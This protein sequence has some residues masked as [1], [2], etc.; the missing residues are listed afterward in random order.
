MSGKT[1]RAQDYANAVSTGGAMITTIAVPPTLAA[2]EF[3]RDY[4]LGHCEGF[5]V[6]GAEGRLG[7]VESV[8]TDADGALILA[9]RA[10]RFGRRV[11]FVRAANVAFVVPRAE[12]VWLATPTE[13]VGS[14]P[15]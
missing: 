4:W 8:R 11:L 9:V 5:R 7:F 14:E 1:L 3:D 15:A 2:S 13:I 10:G 12:R 6:E